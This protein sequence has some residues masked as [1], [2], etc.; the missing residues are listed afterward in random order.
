MPRA[1]SSKASQ[2][3]IPQSAAPALTLHEK[4]ARRQ[5]QQ[6]APPDGARLLSGG[7]LEDVIR[8]RG[9]RQHKQ[10]AG[11]VHRRERQRQELPGL[12]HDLR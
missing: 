7:S 8:V 5:A 4:A 3:P 2:G 10:P 1:Q 12:R 9:A 6:P 11:G